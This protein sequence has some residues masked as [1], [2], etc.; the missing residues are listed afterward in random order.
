MDERTERNFTVTAFLSRTGML[1][2]FLLIPGLSVH[3]EETPDLRTVT[4]DLVVPRM[5]SGAPAP[6]K[7]VREVLPKYRETAVYHAIYLPTDWQEGQ[8]YPVIVEYAGNGPFKSRHGDLSSG[9]VEG[10]NLGYGI[11]AGKGFIWLCL[12]YLNEA[13]TKNVTRWWGNAPTYQPDATLAYCQQAVPWVCEQYGGDEKK[14]VLAGFSR[15]AIAC[16]Y[17]GL[18]ND[19][20]ATLWRAFIP[21]SHYDGVREGWP[22]PGVKRP[23]A[24]ERLQ[25]LQGRPQFISHENKTLDAAAIKATQQYLQGTRVQGQFTFHATGFRNHNDAWVLRPSPA[26]VALRKWLQ[27]VIDR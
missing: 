20:V 1:T 3:G 11:T 5:E 9:H 21:Y 16:N 7:R 14:V 19:Q 15:G 24:L 25:R 12:P 6:G 4:P 8:R 26:R 13:G 18:H 27:E 23:A 2:W 22:F 17:L 10:S